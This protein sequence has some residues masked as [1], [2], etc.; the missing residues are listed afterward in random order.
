[1]RTY[2]R[3]RPYV[4]PLV[5]LL[6]VTLPH[7]SA[8]DWMRG[9][10]AWYGAIGVQAW[11]TGSLWTLYEEPGVPYFNKP[12]V[13]FWIHGL[14]LHVF[15]ANALAARVPS[16]IAAGLCVLATVGTVRAL[17]GRNS[18]LASGVV[19]A[20]TLEFFRRT[21]EI[22]LDLW[23][24]AFLML[25][26]WLIVAGVKH[27]KTRLVLVAGLPLGLALLTKPFLALVG[28][29]L[30]GVWLVWTRRVR[31][32][33]ALLG[34]TV[35]GT[36]IATVWHVSMVVQHGD[37]FTGR[38]FFGEVAARVTGEFTERA[39]SFAKPWWFYLEQIGT[40]WWPWLV[41]FVLAAVTCA[42]G[43]P[44]SRDRSAERWALLWG[45]G[46]LL[47]LTLFPDRRD[48]Y[49]LVAWPG[50]ATVAGLWIARWPW[51]WLRKAWRGFVLWGPAAV[52][53]G[54][55]VFAVLPVRVQAPPY[56]HWTALEVWFEENPLE[57]GARVHVAG[58]QSARAARVY[59]MTGVWPM[60][61]DRT[62]RP[63]VDAMRAGDLVLYHDHEPA[64]PGPGEVVVFDVGD[65]ILARIGD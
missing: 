65:L 36:A 20:L 39:P 30:L 32:L 60:A 57:T 12:P 4:V 31:T 16:V 21:R 46:W 1:M 26:V 14:S 62:G 6:C 9:D 42:R 15:G 29:V 64:A 2:L 45:L 22:S 41:A 51:A 48:R 25:A 47:L 56:E 58:V 50:L 34:A 61:T 33:P 54:A 40:L 28:P 13:A 53:A 7:V 10:G 5:L 55:A 37:A 19:L 49:L 18:A 52:V 63:E 17:A 3:L 8:G 23:L 44:L 43:L 11:Q 27:R 59:L 35:T 24:A 38:Y